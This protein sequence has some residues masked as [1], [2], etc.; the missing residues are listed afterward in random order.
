MSMP[1]WSHSPAPLLGRT[2]DRL[3]SRLLC[4]VPTWPFPWLSAL[5]WQRPPLT[6]ILLS[7]FLPTCN[8]LASPSSWNSKVPADLQT[9]NCYPLLPYSWEILLH[10]LLA[11]LL[12]TPWFP[13]RGK[14]SGISEIDGMS[15]SASRGRKAS[16]ARAGNGPWPDDSGCA[17]LWSALQLVT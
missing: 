5:G 3:C 13:P 17:E 16:E 12:I 2:E 10:F 11:F 4:G 9:C 15:G 1:S 14:V 6:W 8:F 7:P